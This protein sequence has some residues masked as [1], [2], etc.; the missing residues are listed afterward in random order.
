ME[1]HIPVLV[2]TALEQLAPRPQDTIVDITVGG[3]GHAEHILRVMQ[4]G[5]FVGIDA[6][7][8]VLRSTEQRLLSRAPDTHKH[9]LEGNF[10]NIVSLLH[11]IG[12][13]HVD[14]IIADLGWG[15]H[16]LTSGRGFSFT[17]NEVLNMCYGT[18]EGAC[19]QTALDIVN[20]WREEDIADVLTTYGEERWAR[21]I[22]KR[23]IV[24]RKEKPIVMTERLADIV[25]D[26]IPRRLHPRGKHPA[27]KTF[28]ALRIAVNDEIRTLETF[29]DSV[30]GIA[31]SESRLVVITF[32][33]L[34]DRVVKHTFSRWEQ[35]G[36]GTRTK[37]AL[38]PSDAEV[39]ENR[40]AR[41]AKL[42]TFTFFNQI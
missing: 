18:K 1:R 7:A 6:D 10:R 42:R 36:L 25:S 41:S 2:E 17:S 4:G 13:S 20:S 32:H 16:H 22:A 24:G 19:S 5:T 3:G 38:K 30:P 11:A 31:K 14:A 26:A 15:S 21:R 8:D 35:A 39:A 33:S 23:I 12:V 9:F 37:R 28:Q 34:E 40:R 29:L 27:T